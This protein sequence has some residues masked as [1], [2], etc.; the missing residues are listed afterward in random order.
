MNQT[1][2]CP[3]DLY[4]YRCEYWGI[5]LV[6]HFEYL[7]PEVGS[8]DSMGAPYEPSFVASMDVVS[9]YVYGTDVDIMPIIAS[10]CVDFL[11]RMALAD[12]KA[13]K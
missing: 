3:V 11:E 1:P 12:F 2:P 9:V 6:C 4:E 8:V 10:E 13:Y 5:D 7:P